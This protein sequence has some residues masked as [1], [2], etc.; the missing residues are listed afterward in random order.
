LLNPAT[1][2]DRAIPFTTF[3]VKVVSRC[4]LNCSYCYMYNLAD[5]TYLG[6]PPVMTEEVTAALARRIALHADRHD[7]PWVH[8]ILHGGEP[9][10]M[11]KTRLRTWVNQV[12]SVFAGGLESCFSI[13]SNGTMIDDEWIDLL[14]DLG[15]LIGISVDGPKEHHDRHRLDH[16][17]R[18]S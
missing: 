13:Q 4:N 6:Q 8:V 16:K 5:K 9:L 12:R 15:V 11:G 2:A 7:V 17:S 18:G 1:S 3:V 10:L 14:A